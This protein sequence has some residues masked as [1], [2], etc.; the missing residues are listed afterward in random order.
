[1]PWGI[2]IMQVATWQASP[3]KSRK[4]LFLDL[5]ISHQPERSHPLLYADGVGV[6]DHVFA[7]A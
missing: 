2:F 4:F 7:D 5:G 1:M 6:A 3:S